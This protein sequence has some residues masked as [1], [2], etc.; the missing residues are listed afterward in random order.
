MA[1][2]VISNPKGGSGKSTTGFH[3]IIALSKKLQSNRV[4]AVDFDM[5]G[6]LT[7]AFFRMYL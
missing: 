4:L 5:Q 2:F 1:V 6:D 7:D 3:F